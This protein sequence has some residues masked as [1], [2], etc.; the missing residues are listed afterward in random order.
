MIVVGS[1]M[2][3]FA[4]TVPDAWQ[5]WLKRA[6]QI[7]QH[8][9]EELQ[10]FAA[11]EVDARGIEFF[12]PMIERLKEV[13][14]EYWT[15]HLDDKRTEV[16]TVN[17]IRHITTGRNL[18]QEYALEK[19]ATHILFLDAD[20][21]APDDTI[22]RLLE[23][24]HPIVGGDVVTY[25]LSGPTVDGYAFPVQSHMNTAGFLMVTKEIFERIRWRGDARHSD[26]PCY[27]SDV[28]EIFGYQTHVRKDLIGHHFPRHVTSI[29]KRGYNRTVVR[30]P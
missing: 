26:D 9:P 11:I 12:A 7:K 18:V 30:N 19:D 13:G 10:Y 25:C 16:T 4:M 3:T 28:I 8:S 6:E 29:E 2:T 5:S 23:M 17:R 27:H 22:P 20:L 15:Y 1:T 14:G 24:N 21:Q